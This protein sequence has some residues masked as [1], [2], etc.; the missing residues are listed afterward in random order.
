LNISFVGSHSLAEALGKTDA[1]VIVTQVVPY[2]SDDSVPIVRDYQDDLKDIDWSASAGFGDLEGYIAARILTL[3][4][5]NIE[6]PPTREAIVDALEALGNFDIGLGV[7]LYLSRK[8]HQASHRV[9]PT[10][11][12]AGQ[13]VP[14]Q[15][16]DITALTK[17]DA[18]P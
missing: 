7:T 12:R 11:L 9:W 15:W 6:G 13:F 1:R 18:P 3:A 4:L 16:T 10:I 5:Q 2:P 8:E 17:G 14:F